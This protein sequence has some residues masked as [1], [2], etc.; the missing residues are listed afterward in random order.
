MWLQLKVTGAGLTFG[1]DPAGCSKR[2]VT[3]PVP[4]L[5]LLEPWEAAI[6]PV[7]LLGLLL[8]HG[9]PYGMVVTGLS[10]WLPLEQAFL[11]TQM[12]AVRF[13]RIEPHVSHSI[14]LATFF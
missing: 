13:L 7:S 1:F 4:Q 11:E 8:G 6:A 12:E 10:T 5:R 9:L 3:C 2:L 14:T